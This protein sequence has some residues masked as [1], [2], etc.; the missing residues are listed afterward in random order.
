MFHKR[1]Q[2]NS[3]ED[4][5]RTEDAERTENAE[6]RLRPARRRSPAGKS[7]ALLLHGAVVEMAVRGLRAATGLPSI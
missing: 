7:A 1:S 3:A 6:F 5:E 2:E 4:T